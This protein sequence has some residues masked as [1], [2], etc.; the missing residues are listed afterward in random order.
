MQQP[1]DLHEPA[2]GAATSMVGG[3][4]AL[5]DL[6]VIIL[7]LFAAFAGW[8]LK[9]LWWPFVRDGV[10]AKMR[11]KSIRD[12][13]CIGRCTSYMCPCCFDRFHEPFRLRMIVHQ[14]WHLRR[15]EM[16]WVHVQCY[17]MVT[18]G[19]NP[20]KTTTVRTVPIS[21]STPVVWNDA[22][23]LE[24]R[25]TDEWVNLQVV[26]QDEDDLIG[27]AQLSISDFF[28]QMH[29]K[30]D[31][32][33]SLEKVTKKLY[34]ENEIGSLQ[35]AGD[36]VLSLYATRPQK[37]LPPVLPGMD[38]STKEPVEEEPMLSSALNRMGLGP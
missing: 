31:E 1:G 16:M 8:G 5:L 10:L 13:P 28:S 33:C 27:S 34:W 25:T 38:L 37:P 15:T 12:K 4:G 6:L 2:G 23:D 3:V 14:A 35:D 21:N 29:G 26:R 20:A 32:V 19:N 22:L 24:V 9:W 11:S 36:I 30:L 7:T 17:V 18:C